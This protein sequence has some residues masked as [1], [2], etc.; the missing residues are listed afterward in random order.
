MAHDTNHKSIAIPTISGVSTTG[1]DSFPGFAPPTSN[2][3]YTPNQFFDVVLP[4]ASR[5]CVRIVA[6]LIRKTLGWCDAQGNPQRELIAVSNSELENRAGV[7]HDMI[8]RALTEAVSMH[9]IECVT[10]GR[11][12]SSG[13]A[14]ETAVYSLKWDATPRYARTLNEFRGFYEGEGHRTDIPNQFFDILIPTETIAETQ[15]VGAVIRYSIGFVAKHG[16]RRQQATLAYSQILKV[17]GLSSRRTL[18]SAIKEALAKKYIVRLDAGYFSARVDERRS[19]TYA[20]CWSDG[21]HLEADSVA[22]DAVSITPKRIPA[23]V[24]ITHSEKDT[25]SPP[26]HSERATSNAPKRKPTDHSEKDTIE[27]KQLNEKQKQQEVAAEFL[28]KTGFDSKTADA[29]AT[30]FPPE[31]IHQ[32][33]EWLPLRNIT[34]S[35]AGLLRRAIEGDWPQPGKAQPLAKQKQAAQTSM[36]PTYLAWLREQHD[37]YREESPSDYRRFL[38]KRERQRADL[39]QERAPDVRHEMLARHTSEIFKLIE[40][41][42]FLALPDARRWDDTFNQKS[43]QP[44]P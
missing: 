15:V 8:R 21:F 17:S 14:G 4:N 41:Q 33:L 1:K 44:Q 38:A 25:S 37:A 12:R 31:K 3:T 6:Y 34:K 18:A 26:D 29:L 23:E 24:W 28:R 43:N 22:A 42:K 9:F 27:T 2:T 30:K 19:A 36:P 35:R 39:H 40:F 16:R 10:A 32:Q 7:G 5:G 20:V 13:D 11:A